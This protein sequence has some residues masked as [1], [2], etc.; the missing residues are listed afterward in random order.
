[1]DNRTKG[2]LLVMGAGCLW[3]TFGILTKI[4]YAN[5]TLGPISL[6]WYRLIFAIP[7]IG[8]VILFNIFLF[9]TAAPEEH[10]LSDFD[11]LA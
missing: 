1:L 9:S 11:S 10:L 3:G 4:T 8:L 2:A 6:A 5:T 7:F